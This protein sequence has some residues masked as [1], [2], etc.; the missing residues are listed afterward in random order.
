M[1]EAE[2]LFW[3]LLIGLYIIN[4]K[5]VKEYTEATKSQ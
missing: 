4:P 3:S 2:S 1:L 5:N